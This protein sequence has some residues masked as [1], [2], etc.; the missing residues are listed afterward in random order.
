MLQERRD[1]RTLLC[2]LPPSPRAD[3]VN[4]TLS[5]SSVSKAPEVGWSNATFEY[6]EGQVET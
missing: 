6:K 4:V 1:A 5:R 2:R 3:V